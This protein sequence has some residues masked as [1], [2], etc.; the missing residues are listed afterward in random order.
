M[1]AAAVLAALVAAAPARAAFPNKCSAGKEK[2]VA[3][4]TAGLL[5]CHVKAEAGGTV[6]DS[7]CLQ[8][9]YAK[10]D[11]GTTPEKGCFERLESKYQ[12]FTTDDTPAME[13]MVDAFVLDIV[14]DLDPGYP[15]PPARDC[16]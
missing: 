4:K 15:T 16:V 5:A 1:L 7:L 9:A 8:K 6:P 10:F 13:A 11:G 3:T 12:C 2:C 14:A